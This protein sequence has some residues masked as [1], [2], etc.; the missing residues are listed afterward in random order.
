ME[1]RPLIFIHI[2]RAAGHSLNRILGRCYPAS[3]IFTYPGPV[4]QQ[5]DLANLDMSATRVIRGHIPFGIG[6]QLGVPAKYV[7]FLRE[8]VGRIVSLHRYIGEN[9]NHHLHEPVRLMSLGEF[10]TSE[11]DDVEVSN[12]QTRQLYGPADRPPDQAML[13]AAKQ[14]LTSFAAVGVTDRFDESVLVLRD[15]IG[16]PYPFHRVQNATSSARRPVPPETLRLIESR[17]QLDRELY[18]FA[19]GL[20][21][22]SIA[23]EGPS[24]PRRLATFR[25]LNRTAR[26]YRATRDRRPRRR[27][28]R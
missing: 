14:H 2:P 20:L 4:G 22:E 19:A 24:F 21:D 7:T 15:A 18:R 26:F 23:A 12:G 8:P 9:P 27:R 28:A 25:A 17:N 16:C 10:V 3:E 13:E 11:I 1:Q 6:E 5:V